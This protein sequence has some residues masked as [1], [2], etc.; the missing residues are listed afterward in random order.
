MCW[1]WGRASSPRRTA[2]RP[3]RVTPP[4][5]QFQNTRKTNPAPPE[6]ASSL[7]A[8]RQ[9]PRSRGSP[10][11][12]GQA[13]HSAEL[14]QPARGKHAHV[15]EEPSQARIGGGR[16]QDGAVAERFHLKAQSN[17]ASSAPP[18]AI[19]RRSKGRNS[20]G[21][22]GRVLRSG[23]RETVWIAIH[24]RPE[25]R[26]APGHLLAKTF[27]CSTGCGAPNPD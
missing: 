20:G 15:G 12:I 3:L 10:R 27:V 26:S 17:A 13:C 7:P 21:R 6:S 14:L 23:V 8:A 25:G 5:A 22:P 16:L 2:R 9:P 11:S 4:R 18:A 1:C 19:P 24:D